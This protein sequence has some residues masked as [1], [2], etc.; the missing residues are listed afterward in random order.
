M[1]TINLLSS[2]LLALSKREEKKKMK[3]YQILEK[4]FLCFLRKTLK[5]SFKNPAQD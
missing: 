3:K 1:Q 5:K 4:Q 2:S